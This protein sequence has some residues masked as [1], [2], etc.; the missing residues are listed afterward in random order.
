MKISHLKT[1]RIANPLGFAI[2]KPSF[3]WIV[4]D[5]N[6]TVQTAARVIIGLDNDFQQVIFDSGKV[7]G[8]E[9]DSIGYRPAIELQPRTRYFWKVKV[10]G[11]TES[12]DSQVAWFETAKIDEAWQAEW[13]TPEWEDNQIHPILYKQFQLPS[14]VISA[15]AYICGLGLYTFNLN[16]RR[17][18]NEYFTPY[19]N[20]C[21]QW[22]Q[23]Q[24]Y[25]I[26]DQL[27]AG[28][29]QISVMLGNG[30]YKGRYGA[31]GS[32]VGFYGDRFALICELNIALEDG[33]EVRLLSDGSWKAQPAPITLSD[34]FDG[35][36]Q[37][38]RIE[39]VVPSPH[40][41]S[42]AVP[43]KLETGRLEARRSLPVCIN[44]KIKPIA[45]IKTPAGE[46]VLDFGQNLTGWVR[47]STRATY[48]TCIRRSAAR[49]QLFS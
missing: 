18:G 30:W 17:V 44:E 16:G 20:A 48:G 25:D 34:I 47:I 1:N 23:Y 29:N 26:A 36:T 46:T 8:G 37:D 41:S 27:Q 6:D 32:R 12:A 5:T 22:I 49:G 11:E 2:E 28:T 4:D 10:W 24:T 31:D 7:D 35:E 9:I 21:D 42:N 39:K 40:H 38:A 33:K 15:R 3:S 45:L 13:I 14:G 19:C 43:I